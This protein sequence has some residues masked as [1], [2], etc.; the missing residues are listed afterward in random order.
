M[1][2]MPNGPQAN[3]DRA[4]AIRPSRWRSRFARLS[5][6]LAALATL[7]LL[8]GWCG[9]V[10]W[11]LDLA[12]HFRVQELAVLGAAAALLVLLRARRAALCCGVFLL[13]FG[14]SLLP[15]WIPRAAPAP[16]ARRVRVASLNVEFGN[17]ELERVREFVRASRADVLLLI[18]VDRAT[19]EAL[20]PE[21]GA[22]PQRI[23]APRNDPFG[24]ALYS[25]PPLRARRVDELGT[26]PLPAFEAELE[27]EGARATLV[28][29]HAPPPISA[30][31]AAE[32]DRKI[33]DAVRLLR[34]AGGPALLLGDLNATPWGETLERT[35]FAQ[36]F[37]DARLGQ[38]LLPSWPADVPLLGIPIDHCLAS[39][40]W[41]VLEAGL[42]APCGSDHL[43]VVFELALGP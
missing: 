38:G 32:R 39:R 14:W 2:R 36:G 34:R 41:R 10:W 35:A 21:L 12:A 3:A 27:L 20:A 37:F 16:G 19:L 15:Y 26:H 24:L 9:R 22:F 33:E 43:G 4:S 28:A 6:G 25:R 40:E 30:E 29:L 13:G 31:N 11:V 23:E 42:G 17:R 18:E 8:A 1:P 5:A 7:A